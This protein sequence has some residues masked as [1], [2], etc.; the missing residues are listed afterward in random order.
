MTLP[1]SRVTR[2]TSSGQPAFAP[3]NQGARLRISLL[4]SLSSPRMHAISIPRAISCPE[5]NSFPGVPS[6]LSTLSEFDMRDTVIGMAWSGRA[7]VM[8]TADCFQGFK[9]LCNPEPTVRP[10]ASLVSSYWKLSSA[11]TEPL[12]RLV[13]IVIT[14]ITFFRLAKLGQCGLEIRFFVR[15]LISC[16]SFPALRTLPSPPEG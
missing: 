16:E 11:R 10:F 3:P 13:V 14:L 5:E 4:Q 1:P 15:P 7:W 8:T 2:L 6:A 12:F 9:S